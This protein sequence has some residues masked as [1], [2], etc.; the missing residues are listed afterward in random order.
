MG[1]YEKAVQ[2]FREALKHTSSSP[3]IYN[4][5]GLVLAKLGRYD[6]AFEA[7]SKGGDEAQ[8]YNNLGCM[9]LQAGQRNMAIHA[10]EKAVETRPTYYMKAGENLKRTRMNRRAEPLFD[11]NREPSVGTDSEGD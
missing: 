10:F 11:F 9:Y 1:D 5:L 4:N 6:S 8:A 3:K 2:S 7:F